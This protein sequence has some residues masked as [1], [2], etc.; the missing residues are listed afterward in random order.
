MILKKMPA[1]VRVFHVVVVYCYTLEN[2]Q[3]IL[4][5]K[6]NH[7]I[8]PG[9][10]GFPAGK[11]EQGENIFDTAIRELKEETGNVK[12]RKDIKR[13]GICYPTLHHE[14][15]AGKALY[16]WAHMMLC[17]KPLGFVR[18]S[19]EHNKLFLATEQEILAGNFKLIPDAWENFKACLP[20]IRKI[21]GLRV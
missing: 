9:L 4:Q 1:H 6:T 20:T 5:K 17:L 16:F 10:D 3:P 18:L 2:L 21:R 7:P 12:E 14:R 11:V 13:L 8:Y 15:I 19:E